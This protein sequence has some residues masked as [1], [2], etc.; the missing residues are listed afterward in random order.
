MISFDQ[1]SPLA[2]I[3]TKRTANCIAS[4]VQVASARALTSHAIAKSGAYPANCITESQFSLGLGQT[5]MLCDHPPGLP[6]LPVHPDLTRPVVHAFDGP[7]G[8][9]F[10]EGDRK[11]SASDR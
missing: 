7:A 3:F 5:Q 11:A 2:A 1:I 10:L 8:R 9:L 6:G 4:R